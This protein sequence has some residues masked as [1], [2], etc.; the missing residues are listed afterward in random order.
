MREALIRD[1]AIIGDC[2]SA[3]LVSRFGSIDWLCWPR[4]DSSSCFAAILDPSRGG[5]WRIAPAQPFR[6]QRKYLEGSNVLETVFETETGA[7][8]ILDAMSIASEKEES[9]LFLPEHEIVRRVECIRG[10]VELETI[11]EPRPR[12]ATAG[13]R[14]RHRGKLG[15]WVDMDSESLILRSDALLGVQGNGVVGRQRLRQGEALSFSMSFSRDAPAELQPLEC[16][17]ESLE[18]SNSWWTNWIGQVKYEGPY[19]DAVLRSALALKLLTY[20]PSGAIIAAPTTSLPERIGGDLNWDY[21]YCWLRDASFTIRALFG[22]GYAEE[23]SAF[24]GWLLHTTR[25]KSPYLR[26]LYDVFGNSPKREKVLPQFSGYLDSRP[27]RV[28][29]A[30]ES[31]L[32]LD[33]YGEVIDAA[34]RFIRAGGRF[35]SETRT[36]LRNFGL[37]VCNHWNEPDE[38]IWEPRFGRLPHTHS[39]LLCWVALDGL[40]ELEWK[41]HL[42]RTPTDLF[43]QTRDAIRREITVH[44]WNEQLRSYVQI[45]GTEEV[46][47]SLLALA[48]YGFE[49]ASSPRMR[50]TYE[51]I[52]KTLGAQHGL[53]YRNKG[54]AARGEGAFGLCSFWAAHYL[55]IGGGTFEEAKEVFEATLGYANDV[56][57]FAE[58]IDPSTGEPLGN[59]PQGFTHLGLINAAL[60]LHERETGVSVAQGRDAGREAPPEGRR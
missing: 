26:I 24:L 5:R 20:G 56:G 59:F 30:A 19:R 17:R 39:R 50:S 54:L 49:P 6:S 3:A 27:V 12:Y 29:N 25:L 48:L 15:F 60:S 7:I 9:E 51:Q 37:Y 42:R 18:R 34:V 16:V 36:M 58:E 46:D 1:Y 2:R 40:L 28:G 23:A 45:P 32:Q 53:L 44:S 21:R 13:F 47:C 11:F 4:F 8:Q 55:A 41:G 22:L 35:D 52:R 31:Q 10:E 33:V 43:R 57:L 38:G 14:L